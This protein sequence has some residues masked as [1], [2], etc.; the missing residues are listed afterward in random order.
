[1]AVVESSETPV[2][3]VANLPIDPRFL[4]RMDSKR[5]AE[6]SPTFLQAYGGASGYAR[7]AKLPVKERLAYAAVKEGYGTD[8]E[9]ASVT[10]LDLKEVSSALSSLE[11]KGLVATEETLLQEK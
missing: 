2:R 11:T 3:Q 9:I 1:M 7:L 6:Q 5:W 8:E 10:G 4:S